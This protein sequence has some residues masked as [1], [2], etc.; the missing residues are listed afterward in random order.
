M[1]E[2]IEEDYGDDFDEIENSPGKSSKGKSPPKASNKVE[3]Q[4]NK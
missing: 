4:E 1:E 2:E 3:K